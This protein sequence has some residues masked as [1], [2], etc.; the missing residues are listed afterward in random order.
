MVETYSVDV[1]Y[2][3]RGAWVPTLR[4]FTIDDAIAAYEEMRKHAKAEDNVEGVRL[5][6]RGKLLGMWSRAREG[7]KTTAV[8]VNRWA[9]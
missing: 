9:S 4:R 3:E 8:C 2:A 1:R 5:R 6:R 7:A